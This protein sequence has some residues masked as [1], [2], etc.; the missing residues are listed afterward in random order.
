MPLDPLGQAEQK[1]FR[2]AWLLGSFFLLC[3]AGSP[4][5]SGE[6]QLLTL[7]GPPAAL[8]QHLPGPHSQCS[9]LNWPWS[10]AGILQV[11]QHRHLVDGGEQHALLTGLHSQVLQS[12]EGAAIL[13]V[14]GLEHLPV[15]RRLLQSLP[16]TH[17]A[18]QCDS[19]CPSPCW[20]QAVGVA[21]WNRGAHLLPYMPQGLPELYWPPG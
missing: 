21:Q 3:L 10:S 9:W 6:T 1:L 8:A 13:Q 5:L 14:A 4:V 17:T 12:Q 7:V 16:C 18:D 19:G 20:L 2:K 15:G 11:P